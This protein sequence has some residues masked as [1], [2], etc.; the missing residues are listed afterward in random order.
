MKEATVYGGRTVTI[1][2]R[3][4][5]PGRRSSSLFINEGTVVDIVPN[6][7]WD[8]RPAGSPALKVCRKASN[9][10]EKD[11]KIVTVTEINRVV[12][13]HG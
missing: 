7:R 8:A 2:D 9:Q 5:Y 12:P 13:F 4:V 3:I 11:G 6:E 10:W 1:G